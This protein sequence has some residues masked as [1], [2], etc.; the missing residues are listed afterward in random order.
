ME[1]GSGSGERA[2]RKISGT[3]TGDKEVCSKVEKF[4]DDFI[5]GD[6]AVKSCTNKSAIRFRPVADILVSANMFISENNPDIVAIVMMLST[7][8]VIALTYDIYREC[9]TGADV[10]FRIN[11]NTSISHRLILRS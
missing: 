6:I 1:P 7:G 4:V 9:Y 2:I 8:A 5:S 11:G 10:A 3:C